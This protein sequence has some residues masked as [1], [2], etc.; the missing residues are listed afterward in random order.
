MVRVGS[1]IHAVNTDQRRMA[2]SFKKTGQLTY[3]ATI[4]SDPGVAVPG[5]WD[6]FVLDAKDVP[7]EAKF[8]Q[9]TPAAPAT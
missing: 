3:A 8:I 4:H 5:F 1:V 6:L 2:L 7:S 9:I